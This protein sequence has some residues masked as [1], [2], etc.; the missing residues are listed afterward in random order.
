MGRGIHWSKAQEYTLLQGAGIYGLNWFKSKTGDSSNWPGAD[1]GRSRDSIYAKALRFT[2]PG[3]L[4][5]GSYT[6]KSACDKTGYTK[7]QFFRAREALAQKWKR[8]SPKGSYLIYEEQL[9]DLIQ[10][11]QKD[12][13]SKK[14]RLYACLWCGTED[15]IHFKQGLCKLC[16]DRYSHCLMRFGLPVTCQKLLA[17]LQDFDFD[18]DFD[19]G[20]EDKRLLRG[21]ALSYALT[22][23][24][25]GGHV[26]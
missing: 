5:R 7:T 1:K 18:F 2:G 4:T 3:G 8:T 25:G 20:N 11:L 19:L 23:T 15:R 21:R 14:H 13:W 10:W 12:Y 6:L 9:D 22:K 17:T 16:F 24:L 26:D